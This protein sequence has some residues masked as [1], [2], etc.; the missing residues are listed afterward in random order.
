LPVG[1]FPSVFIGGRDADFISWFF[2]KFAVTFGRLFLC[3]RW[4][5]TYG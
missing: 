3:K 1:W 2:Y 5:T 4:K